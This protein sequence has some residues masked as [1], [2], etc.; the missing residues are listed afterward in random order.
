MK[1]CLTVFLVLK[2]SRKTK[3]SYPIGE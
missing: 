1:I 3:D 2:Y